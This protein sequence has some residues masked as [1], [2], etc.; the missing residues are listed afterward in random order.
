MLF[1]KISLAV[2]WKTVLEG[3]GGETD[4]VQASLETSNTD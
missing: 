2:T 4:V 3:A 1:G